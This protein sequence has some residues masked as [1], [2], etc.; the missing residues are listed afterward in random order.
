MGKAIMPAGAVVLML[1]A[2]AYGDPVL[3]PLKGD[4]ERGPNLVQNGGF[5]ELQDGKPVGWQSDLATDWTADTTTRHGGQAGARFERAA[6]GETYW[7][8]QTVTPNQARPAPLVVSGWSKA[9]NVEGTRGGEYSVWVDLQYMDGTP[10]WGQKAPF[11]L[12]THDWQYAEK[13][14]IVSKPVKVATV[15][16]LFRNGVTGSAW[17]DDIALQELRVGRGLVF[18][19]TSAAMPDTAPKPGPGKAVV[20]T[21]DG[22]ELA[23]DAQGRP[24]SFTVGGKPLLGRAPG[25]FWFRDVAANGPWLQPRCAVTTDETGATFQGEETQAGLKLQARLETNATGVDVHVTIIDTTGRDRAVTTYFVL[26]LADQP[27][28]WHDDILHSLPA[29]GGEYTNASGW[30]MSG[31]ASAYPW[32]SITSPQAGLSLSVPMD[33]PRIARLTYNGDLKALYIACDLGIVRDTIDFPSQADYRFSIF[34][35][36]PEWGFRAATA[37]YYERHQQFFQRRL[38]AGGIWMAFGDISKV[39]DF[40]DF[41]FAYDENGGTPLQFDNDNGI[42]SFRYIEPMTYWLPM[43][44]TYPRTYEGAMQALADSEAT[45]KPAEVGWARLTRRCGDFTHDGKYD[46]SLQNQAWCDGA[47]FTVNP[48][49]NIPED[50]DCPLNKAHWDYSKAWADK[51]LMQKTGPRMDGIYL[52]SLPNWGDVRNWRREHWRTVATPLT[53]DPDTKEPLLMQIFSTWQFAKW[54]AD[55]VH[56]RGG[57]MHGNGGALWPCFPA[58]LDITGQETGGIL[59][60]ETM[61]MA[62]TLLR[63]KPYSPLLNTRFSQLPADYHVSYFH[64]SALYDIFPSYFNGDYFENGKWVTGRFF[65]KPELYEQ[66]RPLYKQFIPVLRR[67]YAAGWQPVA[68]ATVSD[69]C[70]AERYGPAADGQEVLFAVYNPGKQAV[71]ATLTVPMKQLNVKTAGAVGLVAGADLLS[72]PQGDTLQ[73]TVPLPADRCEVVSLAR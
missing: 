68:L 70:R 41:G 44:K 16:V 24:A 37:K 10:L 59:S 54:V 1:C 3:V 60:P 6:N 39:K 51:N 64:R 73:I 47:V 26:P 36:D 57:V 40:Q 61:A 63:D 9:E 31:I 34:R 66:V 4:A 55:D 14:F 12:G 30:P 53:F 71:T 48:D 58:L 32:C 23:F 5:E 2:G 56:A 8:S 29:A 65:D 21:G 45:G 52:D 13:V 33:C 62:R 18:D 35:H 50:A 11:E 46:L 25:G 27:W 22:L 7:I 19:R 15:N 42:A 20:A 38:K 69:G 17:F 72:T 28:T 49:P 43:A 67:M